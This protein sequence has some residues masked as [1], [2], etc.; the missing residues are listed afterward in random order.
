VRYGG[1][2]LVIDWGEDWLG[3]IP[4]LR[5]VAILI[6]H[7]HPDHA[8]GLKNGAPCPVYAT[9]EAWREMEKFALTT[10]KVVEPRRPFSLGKFEIE[11]FP[12][13]HSARSPAVGYRIAGGRAALFYV[14][15]VVYIPDR[16]EAFADI[17]LYIGDGATL[18]RSMIRKTPEG[19]LFGHAPMRTQLTWCRKEGI[20]RAVFTHCGSEIVRE[21]ERLTTRLQ[22]YARERQVEAEIAHDGLQLILH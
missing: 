9:E 11:A 8:G 1:K 2:N 3:K 4:P 6:T 21:E 16:E 14:P 22:E 17:K 15:D 10:P 20:T 7:A 13:A 18:A 5:P 12:V 19:I